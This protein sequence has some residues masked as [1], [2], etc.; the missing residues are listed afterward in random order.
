M[1]AALSCTIN[2]GLWD[3]S[4]VPKRCVE[5]QGWSGADKQRLSIGHDGTTKNER[6]S[7]QPMAKRS[8]ARNLDP[9]AISCDGNLPLRYGAV[10]SNELGTKFALG[11]ECR[12]RGQ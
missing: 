4:A 1:S 6:V 9:G 5:R 2:D 3:I 11:W 10:N 7:E 8:V 12:T